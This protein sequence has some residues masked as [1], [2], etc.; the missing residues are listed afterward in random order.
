MLYAG[1]GLFVMAAELD[2]LWAYWAATSV[3]VA[4]AILFVAGPFLPG[5]KTG[6][7]LLSGG[8]LS[9]GGAWGA[10]PKAASS[11]CGPIRRAQPLPDWVVLVGAAV[12]IVRAIAYFS[13]P[14]GVSPRTIATFSMVPGGFLFF[15]AARHS[16]FFRV[17]G[18]NRRN[19]RLGAGLRRGLGAIGGPGHGMVRLQVS[20]EPGRCGYRPRTW[21]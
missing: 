9:G 17:P 4:G 16:G 15:L 13:G 11:S 18:H 7:G 8:I 20:S 3:F 2:K 10:A 12:S 21:L 19:L 5:G 14:N 1:I 6:K